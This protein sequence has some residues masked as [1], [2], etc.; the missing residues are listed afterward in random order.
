MLPFAPASA[1]G[2]PEQLKHLIDSAHGMGLMVFVD[3]IYNH[4]GPDGNY[5][6]Q[7]AAAFFRDDRQTPWA[8]PSISVAA[9]SASSSMKTP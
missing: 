5:L 4:F 1:Y 7:Y 6:A 9:K 3:V 8:R 2:T